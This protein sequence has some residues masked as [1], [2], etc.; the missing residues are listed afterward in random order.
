M[1]LEP[2]EADRDVDEPLAPRPAEGV[3]DDDGELVAG[4]RP[5]PLAQRAR[6]AVGVLGQQAGGVRVHVGLVH[7]RVGADE[8]V[9]RLHDEHALGLADDAPA[10]AAG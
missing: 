3:G 1:R 6:G 9:M 7:A 10:L 4:E 8:A 5:Q 2:G